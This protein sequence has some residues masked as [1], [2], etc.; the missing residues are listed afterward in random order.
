MLRRLGP[1]KDEDK[2]RLQKAAEGCRRLADGV[3]DAAAAT[4]MKGRTRTVE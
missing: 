1:M 4:G 3:S 2:G